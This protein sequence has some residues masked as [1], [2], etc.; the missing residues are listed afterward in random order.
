MNRRYNNSKMF[1]W[2]SISI[3]LTERVIFCSG[4]TW[5]GEWGFR[6]W[7]KYQCCWHERKLLSLK[8]A[9]DNASTTSSRKESEVSITLHGK[10]NF[11]ITLL[12]LFNR[13]LLTGSSEALIASMQP[14]KML[15]IQKIIARG[16]VFVH[17]QYIAR[18]GVRSQH[19]TFTHKLC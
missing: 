14:L 7:P 12:N 1:C 10:N 11:S 3:N 18:G 2:Q 13:H 19:K 4:V 6:P 16:G 15:R 17:A 8:I 9:T 5:S